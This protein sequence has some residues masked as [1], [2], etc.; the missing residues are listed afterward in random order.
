MQ[1]RK[2]RISI[3]VREAFSAYALLTPWLIGLGMFVLYPL[4]YSLYM[5][6]QDVRIT[7]DGMVMKPIGMLNYKNAFLLDNQFSASLVNYLKESLLIIPIIVLF[8][9]L[10]AILLN[11]KYPG[12]TLFRA[13]FFL[14]VIFATG[15]V[16]T[17]IFYQGAAG[18]SILD[19]YNIKPYI[20][21]NVPQMFAEPLLAVLDK[22]VI[23]LWYSGVQ[24][25]IIIAGLQTIS[26]P[27]YE[28]AGIDGASPWETF[29][30]ITLPALKPFIL[31]NTI[32]TIVD[33]FTF[34]FSP[35]L[36]LIKHHMKYTGY[37]YASALGWIYFSIVFVVI[38]LVMLFFKRISRHSDNRR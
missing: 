17:E 12:K 5:S 23:V 14:P 29:W 31:L 4:I 32:Y 38:M 25:I 36:E 27:V 28:A 34:P 37:G 22:F 10:V 8:A 21:M 13:V 35:I 3:E 19:Q 16:L 20:Q 26:K 15:Q 18:L 11:M 2:R 33:L 1:K 7:G 9:L 30:K 24:I 6:F